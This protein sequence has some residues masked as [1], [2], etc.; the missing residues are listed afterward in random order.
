MPAVLLPSSSIINMHQADLAW[1]T[2]WIRHCSNH[3]L[4]CPEGINSSEDHLLCHYL[5]IMWRKTH[6]CSI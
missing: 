3:R 6:T 4:S 2:K 1:A 5:P